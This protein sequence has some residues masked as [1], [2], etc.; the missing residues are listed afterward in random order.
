MFG[1]GPAHDSVNR[2]ETTLS[3]TTV[4]GLHVVAHYPS[5]VESGADYQVIV[6]SFGYSVT[7][8]GRSTYITAFHLPSGA[9]AWHHQIS[10]PRQSWLFAPAV[11]G[12]TVVVGG[13]TKIYA[14]NATT[15]AK[16]WAVSVA[17]GDSDFNEVTIANNI[18]YADTYYG[19]PDGTL[20]AFSLATG[21]VLW[22]ATP[23]GCC[24][25]GAV[26]VSGGLAYVITSSGLLAYNAATGAPVFT[27]AVAAEG[28]TA[29]VSG[30][31]AFIQSASELQALNATTGALLWTA[32][33]GNGGGDGP[34]AVDGNVVVA[35]TGYS[36]IAVAASSGARLWTVSDGYDYSIPSIAN[37]V[38]Y[39]TTIVD[40]STPN[41]GLQAVDEATGQILYA[42]DTT[43]Q[44]PVVSDGLV[45]AFCAGGETVWGL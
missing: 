19:A 23:P 13:S 34:P 7:P 12:T 32:A 24:L 18:V 37:G 4:S 31:V 42:G 30:G 1:D 9:K 22:S 11:S 8:S 20:Y 17:S 28:D 14:F 21:H 35:G 10:G 25:V 15:G 33:L 44:D 6:G 26:S 41:Q 3:P 39:G 27:A 45:Y 36:L 2:A 43:C 29:A 5:W 38:V 16:Q 40:A